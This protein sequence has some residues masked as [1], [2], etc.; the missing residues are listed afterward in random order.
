MAMYGDY[1]EEEIRNLTK[2]IES[3]WLADR[4]GGFMDQFREDF[5]QALG[6]KHA[7]AGA[8]AMVL[9][10]ATLAAI[11][12]GAGD[13]VICDPVVQFHAIACLHNNIVPVWADVR[14]DNFLMDPASVE[15]RITERTKAI[16]VTHLWGFPAEVDRLRAIADEHSIYLLEDCAHAIFAEY[17][18]RKLGTWGHVGTFSF[19]MWKQLATG[20]GG[21]AITD[22]DR[23]AA[24]IDKRIIFGESP[25]VLSSNYRMTELQAA[26]GVA[27]LK[28]VP[29]Y[30]REYAEGRKVLD[31]AISGCSWLDLRQEL[32]ES[33]VAPY[34]WSCLFHG[35]RAGVD[36]NVFKA[37]LRQAGADCGVGFMQR[38]AYMYTI[39]RNPNAYGNKGCPYNCHLYAGKVDWPAGLCPVAEDVI[40]RMVHTNNMV[41][42]EK[43]RKV[44]AALQEAIALAESGDIEPLAYTEVDRQVLQV[45]KEKG[46]LE[47]TEVIRIF[48]EQ[49]WD[50]F[51]EHSMWTIMENLRDRL[52]YKLSH[53]GPRKFAYHDLS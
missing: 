6:A 49:G 35:E 43:A 22:D 33:V 47:P 11:G 23:L 44:A 38:P 29:G 32:P 48:D 3:G 14:A 30:L 12:A 9:M 1:G 10:Q 28:K 31:D 2:V 50:H 45:V 39:L 15:E 13:E 17:K 26:V 41:P 16:W 37:A 8:T 52:P 19:N 5:A 42:V 40:P 36:Y 20:E 51:D 4:S 18:G 53:A 7:I 25:E 24:E 46:P 27:Q 34:Y 21:M